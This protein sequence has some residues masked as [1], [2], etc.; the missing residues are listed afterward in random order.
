MKTRVIICLL[1]IGLISFYSCQ[2]ENNPTEYP[3]KAEVIGNNPDCGVYQ[4]RITEGQ[5]KVGNIVGESIASN[6]YIAN[7]LPEELKISGL[8][9]L[10]DLRKP[11]NNELGICTHM[12][13]CYPWI[14]V[15]RAKKE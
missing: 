12:G 7:N 15:T 9:I 8:R 10:L 13:P 4:I 2:K 11:E 14:Y 1:F 5:D 6:I 3:F